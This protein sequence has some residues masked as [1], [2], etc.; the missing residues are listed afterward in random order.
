MGY[1]RLGDRLSSMRKNRVRP[2]AV[3]SAGYRY[4]LERLRAARLD[5]G[6]TQVEAAKALRRPQSFVSKCERG[7]RRIDPIDLLEFAQLYRRPLEFFLPGHPTRLGP[8]GHGQR[9]GRAAG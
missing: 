3:H 6:I 1:L 2:P 7:E 8:R 9:G 4:L 5:A